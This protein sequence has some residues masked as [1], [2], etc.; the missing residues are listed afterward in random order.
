VYDIQRIGDL[1]FYAMNSTNSTENERP[2]TKLKPGAA[3]K[4]KRP[5]FFN[6]NGTF[7]SDFPEFPQNRSFYFWRGMGNGASDK[8]ELVDRQKWLEDSEFVDILAIAQS[9]PALLQL[10]PLCYVVTK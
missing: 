7:A 1:G 6:P 5:V 9:G 10:T 4:S 3:M 8:K 2:V